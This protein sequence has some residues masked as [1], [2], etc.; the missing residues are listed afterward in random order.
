[1][2]KVLKNYMS[3]FPV[4]RFI[5][6]AGVCAALLSIYPG[7]QFFSPE[8]VTAENAG[9]T[10]YT[11]TDSSGKLFFV[12]S[13]DRVPEE[14]RATAKERSDLPVLNRVEDRKIEVTPA[15]PAAASVTV[16]VAEWCGY[17]RM[18]EAF[19]KGRGITYTRYD[20]ETS[21]KGRALYQKH[22]TGGVPITLVDNRPIRGFDPAAILKALKK[23]NSNGSAT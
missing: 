8:A 20:I 14:F 2:Q 15:K 21:T 17:C 5:I 16:L 23:S 7:W 9:T 18:L 12:D 22:G 4:S 1:M 19:L 11:Y 13:L 10:I 3:I 6:S